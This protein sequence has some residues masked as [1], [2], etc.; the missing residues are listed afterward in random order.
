MTES[1]S[2]SEAHVG[3]GVA[4]CFELPG[5][6]GTLFDLALQTIQVMS[7][8]GVAFDRP[9]R[10]ELIEIQPKAGAIHLPMERWSVAVPCRKLKMAT[11]CRPTAAQQIKVRNSILI[12][13]RISPRSA[14]GNA[15]HERIGMITP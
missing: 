10:T 1:S 7:F 13:S 2:T 3:R 6:I 11:S 12:G 8:R 4:P 14:I 9:R 5:Q 15:A